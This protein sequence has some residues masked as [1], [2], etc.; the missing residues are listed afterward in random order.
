MTGKF[1]V[2]SGLVKKFLRKE[3]KVRRIRKQVD[4][5]RQTYWTEHHDHGVFLHSSCKA[6]TDYIRG[7]ETCVH[8]DWR[9][10]ILLRRHYFSMQRMVVL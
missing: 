8:L 4:Q 7:K 1:P 6:S 5:P 10:T 3:N 9:Y 2:S